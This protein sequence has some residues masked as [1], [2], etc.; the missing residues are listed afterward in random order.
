[1]NPV[2]GTRSGNRRSPSSSR[3][4]VTLKPNVPM[5]IFPKVSQNIWKDPFENWYLLSFGQTREWVNRVYLEIVFKVVESS[6]G[7]ISY[8]CSSLQCFSTLRLTSSNG[9]SFSWPLC[10]VQ[11][12]NCCVFFFFLIKQKSL[13]SQTVGPNGGSYHSLVC[14]EWSLQAKVQRQTGAGNITKG[15][16]L[17]RGIFFPHHLNWKCLV[18]FLFPFF[19]FFLIFPMV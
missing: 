11:K 4:L 7:N 12:Q 13:V 17:N 1:M 14:F 5:L 15:F 3:S 2:S 9:L 8:F 18:E 19:F 10:R 6:S 16:S